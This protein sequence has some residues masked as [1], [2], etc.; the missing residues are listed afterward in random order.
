[1]RTIAVGIHKGGTG[2][3]TTAFNL[4]HELARSGRRVLLV[5]LDYQGSLTNMAGVAES[6]GHNITQV[7]AGALPI[8]NIIEELRPTLHLA[9][10]DIELA[11]TELT[12]SAKIGREYIL[13]RTLAT[14]SGA[15]DVCLLDCPPSLSV[16]TVNALAAAH[17]V[18]VPLQP[19]STD[20]RALELFLSTID[21]IYNQINHDLR[22]IGI[23]FTFFDGRLGLHADAIKAIDDA[24]LQLV[25]S[26]GRS[27]RVAESAGAH[28]PVSEYEPD[29]PQSE[30]FRKLGEA[31]NEW[32]QKDHS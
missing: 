15:Y 26:I 13:R 2:K 3:T 1:M 14:I 28:M 23:C 24:G 29:N 8:R 6:P 9:P 19:T 21:T 17:G 11:D 12:L 16:M 30:N 5:D 27:V 31:V 32:L 25:G 10:A 20:L 7:M 18:L 4:G 22:L